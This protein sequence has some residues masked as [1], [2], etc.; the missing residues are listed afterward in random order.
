MCTVYEHKDLTIVSE[1]IELM[2]TAC[3]YIELTIVFVLSLVT[4]VLVLTFLC[5]AFQ[6]ACICTI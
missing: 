5:E 6:F 1:Y 4:L 2:C 3:E